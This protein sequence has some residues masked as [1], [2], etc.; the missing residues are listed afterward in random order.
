MANF[1]SKHNILSLDNLE[2]KELLLKADSYSNF[3]LPKYFKFD[4]FLWQNEWVIDVLDRQ[5]LLNA[6]RS[7]N[8]NLVIYANKDGKYSWRKFELI[9]PLI[10]ISLVN[11]ITDEKSWKLI[12]S[13]LQN[14]SFKTIS[15][16]GLPAI[17]IEEFSQK[18]SQVH[19]WFQEIERESIKLALD[20]EYLYQTD[21]TDCY[22]SIYTHSI[23][24]AL[25]GKEAAKQFR[26]YDA[27]LGNKIDEHLQAMTYGQTN[28]IPQG[29]MLMDLIAE[30]V[31]SYADELLAE[32]LIDEDVKEFKILRYRDDYRI[33]VRNPN[34]GEVIM[35][36]LSQV[37][38]GL[39]MNLNTTKT[40]K[41]ES[42]IRDSIK[43]DKIN[44]LLFPI[45]EDRNI[46]EELI[47]IYLMGQQYP[48]SGSVHKRLAWLRGNLDDFDSDFSINKESI[49]LL[50]NIGYENPRSFPLTMDI[51]SKILENYDDENN[52]KKIIEQIFRKIQLLPNNGFLELWLQRIF[53]KDSIILGFFKR[54]FKDPL[55]RLVYQPE[56]ELFN[57]DWFDKTRY[58]KV[59]Y[60]DV[61]VLSNTDN[62]IEEGEISSLDW[63]LMR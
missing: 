54:K 10:Y 29:S 34:L 28:G 60:L 35:K 14:K 51:V 37:L 59:P 62:T 63:Y 4:N 47:K 5:F 1:S 61:D 53:V 13:R 20:F 6:K 15:C 7:E 38:A 8:V 11:L 44:S 46:R 52:K 16:I 22:G 23:S 42:V 26:G 50:I 49:S 3:E 2:A 32:S 43:D 30:I 18:A 9:N 41:S 33:F 55:T 57:Y 19:V 12:S 24:W 25:H 48:N 21:I 31:L 17:E 27:L 58:I 40:K 36:N 39:G 56:K 45:T